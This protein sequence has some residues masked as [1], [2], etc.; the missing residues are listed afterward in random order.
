ML[1]DV[2]VVIS[3][4][5]GGAY[6]LFKSDRKHLHFFERPIFHL[7]CKWFVARRE[8]LKWRD[9]NTL[10]FGSFLFMDDFGN[11]SLLLAMWASLILLW[12]TPPN[13]PAS[14][15]RPGLLRCR[16]VAKVHRQ[17]LLWLCNHCQILRPGVCDV[18]WWTEPDH[19]GLRCNGKCSVTSNSWR[20]RVHFC[21]QRNFQMKKTKTKNIADSMWRY[22]LM[23]CVCVFF[24]HMTCIWICR[25]LP[26]N[27]WWGYHGMAT[28]IHV[29]A[30]L[31]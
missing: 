6:I 1:E 16:L 18:V 30:F 31:R 17:A 10:N 26:K 29:S 14:L 23:L 25:L 11:P 15:P 22:F 21:M 28:T 19:G 8:M 20:Y 13:P 4:I 3:A 5:G 12:Y 2:L 27:L 9:Y 24:K 7:S